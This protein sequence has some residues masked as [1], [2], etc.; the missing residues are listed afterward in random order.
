MFRSTIVRRCVATIL[1][2][3]PIACA[4][5]QPASRVADTRDAFSRFEFFRQR[6]RQADPRSGRFSLPAR[7]DG[8]LLLADGLSV[9]ATDLRAAPVVSLSG[10]GIAPGA[11]PGVDVAWTVE[12]SRVEELRLFHVPSEHVRAHYAVRLARGNTLSIEDDR[13]LVRDA[14]GRRFARTEPVVAFDADGRR[15]DGALRLEGDRV[16]VDV[17]VRGARFPVLLD[18]AWVLDVSGP[19]VSRHTAVALDDGRV[20]VA[21][22]QDLALGPVASCWLYDPA[23]SAWSATGALSSPR[24]DHS[25]VR[26]ADGRVVVA[27]GTGAGVLGTTEV[28]D[29]KK[30][31]WSTAGAFGPRYAFA[32]VLGPGGKPL[33]IG[34]A[35]AHAALGVGAPTSWTSSVAELDPSTLGWTEKAPLPRASSSHAAL[36]LPD[37]RVVVTGGAAAA[38]T[39]VTTLQDVRIF[40]GTTWT[41]AAPMKG[42]RMGHPAVV[43][44]SNRVLVAGGIDRRGAAASPSDVAVTTVEEWDPSSDDWRTLGAALPSDAVTK[45]L[46]EVADRE[47]L[48]LSNRALAP[49]VATIYDPWARAFRAGATP[50]SNDGFTATPLADGVLRVGLLGADRYTHTPPVAHA[51][52][53]MN[54]PRAEH[55]ATRV[56]S[57]VLLVGGFGTSGPLST[58]EEF[59]LDGRATGVRRT[60]STPRVGHTATAV[61]GR[62]VV[63]GGRAMGATLGSAEVYD[64]ATQTWSALPA[65][66]EPREGHVAVALDENRVLVAGGMNGSLLSSAELF[67]LASGAWT[68]VAPM[69]RARAQAGAA[70]FAKRVFVLGGRSGSGVERA[71]ESYDAASNTWSSEPA[72]FA[73]RLGAFVTSVGDTL[74]A[75][76]DDSLAS[77]SGSTPAESFQVG[78]IWRGFATPTSSERPHG[79]AGAVLGARVVLVGGPLLSPSASVDAVGDTSILSVDGQ[80]TLT[81]EGHA[82]VALDRRRALVTGGRAAGVPTASAEILT[83]GVCRADADCA[84]GESCV[85]GR[86]RRA[87]GLGRAC[88]GS[89]ACDSGYCVDGV[90]CNGPCLGTCESCLEVGQEG[91]CS[92]HLGTPVGGRACGECARPVCE[93]SSRSTCDPITFAATC[94]SKGRCVDGLLVRGGTCSLGRCEPA[95]AVPCADGF[96]CIPPGR[97]SSVAACATACSTDEQCRSGF[98]CASGRCRIALSECEDREWEKPVDGPRRSCSPFSCVD[99]ACVTSCRSLADCAPGF[100]CAASGACVQRAPTEVESQGCAT[101][102]GASRLSPLVGLLAVGLVR[103]RRARR[104][105]T[106]AQPATAAPPSRRSS[107]RCTRP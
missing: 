105:R 70:L 102:P 107:A 47:V 90:C 45:T 18:P 12:P 104:T 72:L 35:T 57:A 27:G 75:A 98:R 76:G 54:E 37:G 101:S 16:V 84:S 103:R 89:S 48:M 32:L 55:T 94:N 93:A 91:T 24:A 74:F 97:D 9:V 79:S 44:V 8:E 15:F 3:A 38:G 95:A 25:A 82:V 49:S 41:S 39:D 87:G 73:P 30:G 80:L 4:P 22:G 28:F 106:L 62:V 52:S 23:T 65:M 31:T 46:T 99:H 20:L 33:A 60:M 19:K 42:P 13:L 26:L 17:D 34:G 11:A 51:T 7:A 14:S 36:V 66:K 56:G 92:Q 83:P 100:E 59:D 40:D 50:L 81:R 53:P 63:T 67:D 61:G 68:T 71:V 86:C 1:L 29:P 64:A 96:A 21:G 77:G 69:A 58:S 85:G 5:E 6:A 78:G 10:V 88:A 2:G 43:L